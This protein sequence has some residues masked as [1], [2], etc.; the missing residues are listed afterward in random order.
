V[1]NTMINLFLH[2]NEQ[3]LEDRT[4]LIK[5]LSQSYNVN[6]LETYSSFLLE[7][8]YKRESLALR[9]S[10][11]P[12]QDLKI[13]IIKIFRGEMP[14]KIPHAQCL[15][16]PICKFAERKTC[17]GCENIVP[18]D[19]LL[20]SISEQINTTLYNLYNAN[21]ERARQREERFLKQMFF[22]INEAINEKG[23]EYVETFID[24]RKIK[25][26]YLAINAKKENLK[27]DYSKKS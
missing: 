13:L 6:D 11:L 19:Y 26:L 23:K 10:M 20:I 7:E 3:T 4:S 5:S 24:R 16:F 27:I 9:L 18:T 2:Q 17:I 12:K 21:F 15:T 8:R 1:Y 25:D 14:A 22:L